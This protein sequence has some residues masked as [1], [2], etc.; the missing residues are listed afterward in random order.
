MKVAIDHSDALVIGSDELPE[1]LR[2]K[3]KAI[4]KPVL[5]YYS[6]D[7]F[8]EAYLDFYQNQVLA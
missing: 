5:K 6:K 8:S 2:K 4:D 3:L 1:E 7:S